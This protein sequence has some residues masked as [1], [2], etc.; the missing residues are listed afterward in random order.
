M[1]D[2]SRLKN[3]LHIIIP[4]ALCIYL[5]TGVTTVGYIHVI[6]STPTISSQ[7]E[8]KYLEKHHLVNGTYPDDSDRNMYPEDVLDNCS[9]DNF[10]RPIQKSQ[11][12]VWFFAY[13]LGGLGVA[14]FITGY[15][16][17]GVLQ[18]LSCGCCGIWWLVDIILIAAT[19]YVEA[20]NC[21]LNYDIIHHSIS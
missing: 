11:T 15:T 18:C 21:P 9:F 3:Y 10:D 20:N 8:S 4:I 17:F 5:L 14:R 12:G 6:Q 1:I 19:A 7:T 16:C 13:L 2:I